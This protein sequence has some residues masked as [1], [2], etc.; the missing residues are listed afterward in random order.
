MFGLFSATISVFPNT[1]Y[2]PITTPKLIIMAIAL[3]V[4]SLFLIG[5]SNFT[6]SKTDLQFHGLILLF[7]ILSLL[8]LGVNHG[9]FSEKL[10]GI[11]GI[12][13]GFLFF[14]L[15]GLIS[16]IASFKN[17][18][19]IF[20]KTLVLTSLIVSTV[21]ILQSNNLVVFELQ[22]FYSIPSSTL[23]NP[24]FVSTFVA[25]ASIGV[26]GLMHVRNIGKMIFA[27]ISLMLNVYVIVQC[28][29]LQGVL[30][31]IIGLITF[32]YLEIQRN[33]FTSKKKSFIRI[34]IISVL[35]LALVIFR[36]NLIIMFMESSSYSRLDYWRA[37]LRMISERPIFGFGFDSFGDNHLRYRDLA[38]VNRFGP[39]QTSES[40]HNIVVE[41]FVSGGLLLGLSYIFVLFSPFS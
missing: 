29:S 17:M 1:F 12:A 35:I 34:G 23:G 30:V 39:G 18:T 15:L 36:R 38:A 5:E 19:S 40:P 13:S 26:L 41:M 4:C 2:D 33:H 37:S 11:R 10:F 27:S 6:Y 9:T 21:F 7:L 20:L 14:L 25:L 32:L 31:F 22:T 16:I 28:R 8:V 24:N 3:T